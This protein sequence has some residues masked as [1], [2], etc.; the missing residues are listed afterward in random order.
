MVCEIHNKGIR[1]VH[2][3]VRM[4]D[5]ADSD[6]RWTNMKYS[7][8]A[9]LLHCWQLLP[10]S[11]LQSLKISVHTL[12]IL[13]MNL[14][15]FIGLVE[16][17]SSD[18]T[19]LFCCTN[20]ALFINIL[21]GWKVISTVWA[22]HAIVYYYS[23]LILKQR[24]LT[25]KHDVCRA[26][27]SGVH[28]C[29]NVRNIRREPGNTFLSHPLSVIFFYIFLYLQTQYLAMKTKGHGCTVSCILSLHFEPKRITFTYW[30]LFLSGKKQLAAVV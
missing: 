27:Q 24:Y 8:F 10:C 12:D 19:I 5:S 6:I 29:T 25:Y 7:Y 22:V 21:Y 14:R 23:V 20:L 26:I 18:C 4:F 2:M 28:F 1:S 3:Y 16:I 9:Y 17:I 15:H 13:D 11:C 30:P